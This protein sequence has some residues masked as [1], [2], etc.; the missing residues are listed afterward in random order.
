M[1]G[2]HWLYERI[3]CSPINFSPERSSPRKPSMFGRTPLPRKLTREAAGTVP[4]AGS[5]A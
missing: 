3:A 2:G 1:E 5:V 4:A